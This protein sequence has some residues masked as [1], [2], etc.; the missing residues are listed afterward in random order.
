MA[1]AQQ[2]LQNGTQIYTLDLSLCMTPQYLDLGQHISTDQSKSF[3]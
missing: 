1:T 2:L 3:H